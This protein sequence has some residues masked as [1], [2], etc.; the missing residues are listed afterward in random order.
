M[1]FVKKH[2]K[3][4]IFL[5]VLAIAIIIH[6]I[7]SRGVIRVIFQPQQGGIPLC[8]MTIHPDG[9]VV[10]RAGRGFVAFGVLPIFTGAT[11][12]RESIIT[13]DDYDFL[14]YVIHRNE[15]PNLRRDTSNPRNSNV[16]P[17]GWMFR[18][19]TMTRRYTFYGPSAFLQGHNIILE[20]TDMLYE[21]NPFDLY[22]KLWGDTGAH[23][24][25]Y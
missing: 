18:V 15:R 14:F 10:A 17:E 20:F 24:Y 4:S 3:L 23:L 11:E 16:M 9:R 12:R 13:Q 7:P 2:K 21:I 8:V 6:A 22:G 25:S 1:K 5:F 19:S